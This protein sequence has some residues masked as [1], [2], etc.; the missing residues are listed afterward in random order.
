MDRMEDILG[1]I[2]IIRNMVNDKVYVGQ[3][4]GTIENRFKSH[5]K[6]SVSKTRGNYKIYNAMNK[7]G[8]DK[9]YCELLEDNIPSSKLD[10]KEISYIEKFDSYK[11]GYNSTP[12]GKS[13]RI[14]KQEDIETMQEMLKSGSTL[15]EIAE[16]F[17]VHHATIMRT[18]HGQGIFCH[19]QIDENILKCW[20]N[21][22]LSNSEIA[23]KMGTKEWTIE[24][25]LQKMNMRRKRVSIKNRTDM[26]F[27]E[28]KSDFDNGMKVKD[29]CSK[30]DIDEKTYHR[31]KKNNFLPYWSTLN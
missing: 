23:E 18:L 20:F 21:K 26:N 8:K 13:R 12:G 22:G 29:I 28:M 9:F 2:Y 5:L 3:T 17:G 27:A 1:R 30:Y 19:D 4:T 25:K 15:N 7:Y 14:Y 11:N 10:E 6:P 31:I 24:R 16:K